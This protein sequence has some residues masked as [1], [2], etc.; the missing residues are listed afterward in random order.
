MRASEPT[1]QVAG[2]DVLSLLVCAR[3][4]RIHGNQMLYTCLTVLALAAPP[5]AIGDVLVDGKK[6]F[7][8]E[9]YETK[10]GNGVVDIARRTIDSK[11]TLAYLVE[12]RLD[13]GI[14]RSMRT[15]DRQRK[16]KGQVKFSDG[17][18][19]YR[20][21]KDDGEVETDTDRVSGPAMSAPGLVSYMQRDD[22]WKQLDDGETV[23]L[24]Y[25]SWSRQSTYGFRLR[26]SKRSTAERMVIAMQPSNW[27]IRQLF[28]A[29]YYTF[30]RSD[31]RLRRYQGQISVKKVEPDGD[32]SD[33]VAD[34]RFR[35]P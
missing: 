12:A 22:I 24:T 18:I 29:I 3:H 9:H 11:G 23:P 28:P 33:V 2:V 21:V 16:L 1:S 25:V 19:D 30:S 17:T 15:D 34:V 13:N 10:L 27:M 14:Q 6:L 8:I 35:Y 4:D 31:R 32:L 5:S 20:L 26:K 7:T